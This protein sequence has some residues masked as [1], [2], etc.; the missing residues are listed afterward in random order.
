MFLICGQSIAQRNDK[1]TLFKTMLLHRRPSPLCYKE[2][3]NYGIMPFFSSLKLEKYQQGDFGYCPRVYCENQPMLPIGEFDNCASILNNRKTSSKFQL[4]LCLSCHVQACQTSLERP[5]WNSTAPSAWTCTPPNPHDIITQTEPISG[6]VSPTCCSWCT[7]SIGQSDQ[8]TSLSPGAFD[9]LWRPLQ[10]TVVHLC[11][12]SVLELALFCFCFRLYG[13]KIHPMAYQ[14]QLQA[15]S[16]FKSPV[17]T[18][19]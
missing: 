3:I 14:L 10:A 13:F 6:Q 7:Q 16:T 2:N 12:S 17:K 15:A 5:W 11:C 4:L 18:I 8:P 9:C 1:K 19:R